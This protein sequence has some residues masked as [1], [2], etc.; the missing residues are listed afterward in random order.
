VQKSKDYI[1]FPLLNEKISQIKSKIKRAKIVTKNSI[2]QPQKVKPLKELLSNKLNRDEQKSIFSSYD[3]VGDIAI[4]DI[5]NKLE[6]K[7]NLIAN[8]ILRSNKKIKTIAIKTSATKGKYRIRKIKPIAG[9][10]T[11]KTIC[12]ESGCRFTVDLNKTYYTNRFSHDRLDIASQ[13]KPNENIL[14]LFSGICPY[15]IVIEKHANPKKII[16]IELNADAHKLAL[17]NIELNRCSKIDAI[18]AD[19]LYE[20]Q[21]PEYNSWADRILMPHP[22]ASMQFFECALKSSKSNGIIHLY[23]FAPTQNIEDPFLQANDIAKKIGVRIKL[24]HIKVV[25]PFSKQKTQIRA[26]IKVI[27]R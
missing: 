1:Y 12:V 14:V 6:H 23:S 21:E 20:L 22:S 13:V 25:R 7:Q 18:N 27:K 9:K 10:K 8:E 11:T 5:P 15:P 3:L 19:V 16:A 17:E 26:D 24:L 4:L 2:E